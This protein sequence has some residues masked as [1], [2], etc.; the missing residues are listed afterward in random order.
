[1]I[2]C[3][4]QDGI[5]Q[6]NEETGR[7][8]GSVSSVIISRKC[9]EGALARTHLNDSDVALRAGTAQQT[10]GIEAHAGSFGKL[11]YVMQGSWKAKN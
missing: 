11:E 10:G 6:S 9:R 1:M 3:R 7:A 5:R 2:T 4:Q 8:I